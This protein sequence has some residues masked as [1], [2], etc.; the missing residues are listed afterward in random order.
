MIL[1]QTGN[2]LGN[3][4]YNAFIYNNTS[5]SHH[6]HA[7]YEI[8]Y[9]YEGTAEITIN[10]T[11]ETLFPGEVILISPY[12]VH[13]IV[14]N[15]GK[16]WVGVFSADFI[17]TFS[18]KHMYA[19]RSK[20]TCSPDVEEFLQKHLFLQ[21]RP[22]HF[23]H[24]SCL[25]MVCNECVHN[26]KIIQGEEYYKFINDVVTYI[27]DHLSQ[28]IH[29]DDVAN[30]LNYEYHY[31][32]SLFH[33]SF[34]I[35]FRSFINYYRFDHACEMLSNTENSITYIA[36]CC[37]FGS[38]RNFNRVFKKMSGSTPSEYRKYLGILPDKDIA[39][40]GERPR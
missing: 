39:Y 28:D 37:G 26:A 16:V 22:A 14:V 9:V 20:F 3:Y 25:Y 19:K 1:H 24:I 31:F 15:G 13:S 35:N 34:S 40:S 12:T 30:A 11:D 27:S 7:N 17:A 29:L 23:M 8:I 36:E 4:H 21:D 32:S 2:S 38:I 33:Q 6:F 10:G 5:Y 18:E